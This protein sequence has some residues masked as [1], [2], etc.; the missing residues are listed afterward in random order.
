ME[1]RSRLVEVPR[2]AFAFLFFFSFAFCLS[3]FDLP[4][5]SRAAQ[6][7]NAQ[8]QVEAGRRMYLG[9]GRMTYCHHAGAMG[10]GG[11]KRRAPAFSSEYRTH[12][13]TTGRPA[14]CMPRFIEP[15]H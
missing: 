12:F 7:Q 3:S 8:S 1:S 4:L 6:P 13:S 15:M 11:P 5:G 14:P 10:G 9:P 2:R